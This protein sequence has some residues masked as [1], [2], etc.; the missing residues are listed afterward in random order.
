M[1]VAQQKLPPPP[2]LYECIN[3]DMSAEDVSSSMTSGCRQ[4]KC[5]GIKTVSKGFGNF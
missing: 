4:N 1:S 5:K 2:P 3:C